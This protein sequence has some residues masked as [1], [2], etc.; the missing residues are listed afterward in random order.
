MNPVTDTETGGSCIPHSVSRSC[1]FRLQVGVARGVA[2]AGL[3]SV[4]GV[5]LRQGRRWEAC[6]VGGTQ[7][8]SA[9]FVH[10]RYVGVA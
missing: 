5:K 1:S 2:V 9:E 4:G 6:R 7:V 8:Q 10:Q 3:G